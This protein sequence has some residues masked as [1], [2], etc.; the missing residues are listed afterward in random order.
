MKNATNIKASE[1]VKGLKFEFKTGRFVDGEYISCMAVATVIEV[2]KTKTGRVN[3]TFTSQ[4]IGSDE[5]VARGKWRN[6]PIA[7]T[8]FLADA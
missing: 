3:F 1:A 2:F 5:L 7:S 8:T 6:G 4:Y